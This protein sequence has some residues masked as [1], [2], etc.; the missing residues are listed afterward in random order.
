MRLRVIAF[1]ILAVPR[2][3]VAQQAERTFT[4]ELEEAVVRAVTVS[5]S[6]RIAEGGIESARGFRAESRWPF[7]GNPTIEFE[8]ARRSGPGSE[9]YDYG[10]TVRQQVEVAGQSF[11]RAGAG[12]R[13]VAAAE[14]RVMDAARVSALEARLAYVTL[15][16]AERRA[17][18]TSENAELA[19]QLA[20]VAQRQL[21][22]GEVN[23]IEFNTAALEAARARSQAARLEAERQAVAAELARR[24]ALTGDSLVVTAAL[25]ELPELPASLNV[26]GATALDRRPDMRAATF[27]VEA[28]DRILAANGRR[29]VPNLEIGLFTG[30]EAGTDDLLGFSVGFSVPLFHRGQA[31]VGAARADRAAAAALADGT[32][33]LVRAE[34]VAEASR[35]AGAYEAERRFATDLL[36]AGM[37]NAEL[38]AVAFEEGELSI[39]DVVVFRA[40]ALATQLEYLEVM[41]D[42]YAAWFSLAAALNVQPTE[43]IETLEAGNA[44]PE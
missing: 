18:L 11:L 43:L 5:P 4:I 36:S 27:E 42:A 22:A 30:Q 31:E 17:S 16:L 3:G 44:L 21:D 14:E 33:R 13:R 23:V 38:A 28:A 37:A 26:S 2:V 6:V 29:I 20:T 1:L 34:V 12:N 40:T 41:A 10:W 35:Y 39:A 32:A 7:S 24:L 9:A 15:H 19:E 25:P 8:R